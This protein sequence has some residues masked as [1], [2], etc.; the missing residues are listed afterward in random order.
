MSNEWPKEGS[1]T[2]WQ[3][4]PRSHSARPMKARPLLSE[5][6][7]LQGEDDSFS[8]NW[9][10]GLPAVG[11]WVKNLMVAA[12]ASAEV[13]VRSPA[14]HSGLRDPV[15]RSQL[16]LRFKFPLAVGVAKKKKYWRRK[17]GHTTQQQGLR[18]K[19]RCLGKWKPFLRII[20][21]CSNSN[22]WIRHFA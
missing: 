11:Q 3:E 17:Q 16:W 20:C 5:A 15:F 1:Y 14:Q 2:P 8:W 13:R 21:F 22:K 19:R 10:R 6:A 9:R 7:E 12:W 4:P 18:P